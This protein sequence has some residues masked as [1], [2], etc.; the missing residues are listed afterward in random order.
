MLKFSQDGYGVSHQQVDYWLNNRSDI[1]SLY[2]SER[3]FFTKIIGKVGSVLDIGCA[4]GGSCLFSRE[5]SPSVQYTGVDINQALINAAKLRFQNLKDTNFIQFDGYHLPFPN[6]AFDFIFSFG[7]FHHLPAWKEMAMEAIRVSRKYVLFDLRIWSKES[8]VN[9]EKSFQKISLNETWDGKTIIQYNIQSFNEL[10]LF[11][12]EMNESGINVKI[13]GYY[14]K[15]TELAVTPATELLMCAVLLE[16][17]AEN[18]TL[19]F[20][21]E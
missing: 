2:K 13:F 18:P 4:A 19:E 21:I 10:F 11:A 17:N 9:S 12:K 15:P 6:R 3:H 1:A 14:G 5:L 16:L 7:V 8:L 20:E